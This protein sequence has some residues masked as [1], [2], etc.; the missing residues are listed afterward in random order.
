MSTSLTIP[1]SGL[2]EGKHLID[3]EIGNEFFE[4]FEESEI[5]VGALVAVVELEKRSSHADLS[6]RISGSVMISCDRCLELFPMNIDCENRLLIKFGKNI[7][8]DDPEIV[9][10]SA[11]EHEFDLSQHFYDYIHL[12]LPIRRVHPDAPGGK[13]ACNPEMLRRLAELR[14][15]EEGETDPRWDELKKLMN[16][17]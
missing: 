15:E 12:A 4:G 7:E 11:E 16:D 3:F 9:S 1:V 13:S 14:T 5:K 10:L 6:I 8:G 17:N 2:K